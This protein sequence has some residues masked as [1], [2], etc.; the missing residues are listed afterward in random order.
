[1]LEDGEVAESE[2]GIQQGASA[3]PLLANVYLHYVYD[4]WVQWWRRNRAQG[5]MFVVRFAD[6]TVVGFQYKSDADQFLTDL[7]E[8]FLKFGL[9]LHPEKT[10]L[11]LFGRYAAQRRQERNEGK[12][13]SFKFLGL[14]HSCGKSRN[15]KFMIIRHTIKKRMRAKVQEVKEEL[16]YRMHAPIKETGKWLASVLVGHYRYYG[17]SCN[18]RAMEQFRY[19]VYC[20][21]RH[22]L[23]RRSQ[24]ARI[25]WDKLNK[26]IDRW[27][28]KPR[29]YHEHPM[30]RF[31]RSHPR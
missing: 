11:I 27:L 13:E 26:I 22:A 10:R 15:G 31:M 21:W 6:D 3:S 18:F 28:P 12:P 20:A 30:V 19:Q 17:V 2:D 14:T 7:K 8:R 9:E 23:N 4:L 16:R 24:K 5:D 1:V 25:T 29:I